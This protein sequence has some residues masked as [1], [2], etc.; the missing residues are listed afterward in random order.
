[1]RAVILIRILVGWV[2]ISEGIQKFLFPAALGWGRFA[3][4]GLPDPHLLAP[5]VGVV[6]IACGALIVLGLLTRLAT[7]PLLAVIGVAIWKTKIPILHHE[8]VWA[9]L[10]EARVDCSMALGLLFLLIVGAGRYAMD[11]N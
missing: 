9:M 3:K 11:K 2:F 4:I 10:H 8:G 5:F 6:E 7:V 1:M